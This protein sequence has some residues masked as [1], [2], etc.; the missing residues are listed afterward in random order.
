LPT[1]LWHNPKSPSFLHQT[2]E[3]GR[4]IHRRH[5]EAYLNYN[6]RIIIVDFRIRAE[7]D[8]NYTHLETKR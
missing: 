8:P 1:V 2:Q 7:A 6:H 3:L 5:H 4:P